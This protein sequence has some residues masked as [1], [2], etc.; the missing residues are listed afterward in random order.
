MKNSKIPIWVNI[1]QVILT[2]IM[3][4]Q[5]YMYF[6]N[7]QMMVDAG[8]AVEGVPTLNL[9]YEMGA[10]TLVMA[11]AAIY[12]LITQDPKQ[13]LVVLFMNVF[14]E[15]FETIIDPLFPL[16]NAPASPMVDFW[17]HIVIVAVEVWALITVLK[18]T[19]KS[20]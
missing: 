19:R 2:L 5:V 17:T 7:H 9:I 1:M 12:V 18:I 14:R 13:F 6:F 10:R 4:G 8:M 20:N 3:L 15:G 16:I 11:I